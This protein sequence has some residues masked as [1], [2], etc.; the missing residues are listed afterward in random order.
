MKGVYLFFIALWLCSCSQE[1][2]SSIIHTAEIPAITEKKP[3]A[4]SSR[5]KIKAEEALKF[6]NSNN[7]NNNFCILIDMSLHSGV[8]RFFVWDFKN[9][10]ISKKYLVGHGCG[11]NSWS[12][13]DSKANPEFSNED[14]SH[15]SSLGKY[16]LEGRG[17]SDWGIN[18]KYLM[19]GLEE[20]NS[21]ALK[22][23]IV[24]HSWNMMSDTEVFP[25][26]SPEGW[27]CPT[28]SNNAMKEIDPMIQKSGKPVLMWI[29]N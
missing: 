2:K 21:N 22:R 23:F 14:G 10:K 12:K 17:Y 26:G 25:N 11:S 20:T 16:K 15:L 3:V 18:I 5:I 28:I 4:D 1:K 13:D 24:F 8:N 7:L 9:N 19:H 6:C 29:Y 27:G